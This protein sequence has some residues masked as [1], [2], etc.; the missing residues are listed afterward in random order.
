MR[1]YSIPPA[2]GDGSRVDL[3][4]MLDV[5]FILLIFFIVTASFLRETGLEVLR[6]DSRVATQERVDIV[7]IEIDA[8][9]EY[10]IEGRNIGP[11]ALRANL[12]RL[13]SVNPELSV[14]V[15][16]DGASSAQG[17]VRALDA[18]EAAGIDEIAVT[19]AANAARR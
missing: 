13:Y 4:P 2:V 5:V 16:T 9:D 1:V 18:A 8:A 19:G 15:R 3:T 17:L 6:G 14:V 12:I 10:W 11:G 7:L